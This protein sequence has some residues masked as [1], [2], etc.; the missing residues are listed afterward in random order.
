MPSRP[1]VNQVSTEIYQ[2]AAQESQKADQNQNT[3]QDQ[4]TQQDSQGTGGQEQDTADRADSKSDS[5]RPS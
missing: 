1:L 5:S 4:T 3:E 2:K